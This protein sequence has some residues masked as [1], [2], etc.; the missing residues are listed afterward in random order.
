[1][2]ICNYIRYDF[3]K[4]PSMLPLDMSKHIVSPRKCPRTLI[5]IA[6]D[7]KPSIWLTM[8]SIHVAFEIGLESE[9]RPQTAHHRTSKAPSVG[10]VDVLAVEYVSACCIMATQVGSSGGEGT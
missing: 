4:Y 2:H 10:S 9:S 1:M 8:Y 6:F 5:H 3:C 7:T